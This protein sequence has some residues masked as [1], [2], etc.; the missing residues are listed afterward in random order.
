MI[1]TTAIM[2]VFL[3]NTVTLKLSHYQQNLT[4]NSSCSLIKDGVACVVT[5]CVFI[6]PQWAVGHP[7]PEKLG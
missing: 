5:R 4:K 6:C 7:E 2:N 3:V 1:E